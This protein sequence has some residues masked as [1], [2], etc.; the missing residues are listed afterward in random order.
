MRTL[1][2]S[3]AVALALAAPI[4]ADYASARTGSSLHIDGAVQFPPTR[5]RIVRHTIRLHLP[6]GSSPLSQ[7]IID[8]PK[9]LMVSNNITI[10]DNLERKIT[11]NFSITN[12][13]VIVNF[14][15]P[16]A[17]ELKL[18]LDLNN[19]RRRGIS[20]AWT[21]QVSAKFV[22]ADVAIPIGI[23]RIRAY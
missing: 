16:V 14:S 10:T 11:A 5:Q 21:Y 7:L 6:Q 22:G 2:Y 9:G 4:F 18:E 19:V 20:N 12:N 13:K 1:I 8:V 15:Q 23:A 3:A 17:P